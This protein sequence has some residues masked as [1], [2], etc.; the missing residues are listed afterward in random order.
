MSRLFRLAVCSVKHD[1]AVDGSVEAIAEASRRGADLIVTPE[2]PDIVSGQEAG[3][4]SLERHPIFQA[5]RAKAK[6]CGIG[7][8]G[9]LSVKIGDSTIEGG[10]A[11]MGFLLDRSGALVGT[12][13]K[14]HPAPSEEFIDT[15]PD[16]DPATGQADPFPVFDF[17]GVKLGI[18][19]C[20]DIH[21][22][23]MFRI[24]MLKG[25]DLVCLPTMYMD[26]TG[27]MLESIEKARASDNQLYLALSRYIE[28]PYL[29][30]KSMGYAK[31]VAPDGRLAVSTG[32]RPGVAVAEID[33]KWRM[34]FWGEGYADMRE[35]YEKIRQPTLYGALLW[36]ADE[37]LA[38]VV[39]VE[40]IG[41][42]PTERLEL[43]VVH[44]REEARRE[45]GG[46]IA[47]EHLLLGALHDA[48][49]LRLLG[50]LGLDA[51]MIRRV[52]REA[53]AEARAEPNAAQEPVE[54]ILSRAADEARATG[55]QHIDP[56]HLLLS[57]ARNADC[58][59]AQVLIA[60]GADYAAIKDA[61]SAAPEG[62]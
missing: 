23:E 60:L 56:E 7:V 10:V 4:H 31:V 40:A 49:A 11:N 30:G 3:Q 25:A 62:S 42:P 45:G 6:E 34:P 58:F 35:M 24:Y 36:S 13:R 54:A 5:Y 51:D 41:L 18:A 39:P 32:H 61:L 12:Y 19:I 52:V 53:P 20:M 46:R 37:T 8:V 29:A 57:L 38:G 2:E 27:D 47:S 44:A 43:V 59:A 15:T 48:E 55:V 28:L 16:T 26:Y 14:K 22:P 33:P 21:F 9:S 17:E 1:E 50:R